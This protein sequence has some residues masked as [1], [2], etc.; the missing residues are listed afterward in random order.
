[1]SKYLFLSF[2]VVFFCKMPKVYAQ[3][4]S[5]TLVVNNT[6]SAVLSD[7]ANDNSVITYVVAL[8][9]DLPY[10]VIIKTELKLAD[11]TLV[12]SKDLS[13]A[14]SFVLTSGTHVF[15]A[16]DVIPLEVMLFSGSYRASLQKYGKLQAGNYQI[17]V[18]IVKAGTFDPV[19]EVQNKF[20]NLTAIQLPVLTMPYADDTLG[21]IESQTAIT[22]RWTPATPVRT[23]LPRY[24]IQVFEVLDNQQSVQ[25]LRS[26]EPLLDMTLTGQTQYIWRPQLSFIDNSF[27]KRFI[28]TIQTLDANNLPLVVT[29]GNGESRSE[30]LEFF[31]RSH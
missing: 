31:V 25:A 12:A 15:Y 18:Q 8:Q 29:D 13:K 5:T 17:S 27:G 9:K 28:W 19:S 22:F 7:W 11:G 16:K 30:P 20:F 1:M 23:G 2:L 4:S 6:P 14:S 21:L 10:P 3:I 24:R 26:N